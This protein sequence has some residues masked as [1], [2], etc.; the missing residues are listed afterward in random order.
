MCKSAEW[1][2]NKTHR[3]FIVPQLI[4][5]V[6]PLPFLSLPVFVLKIT[7][8]SMETSTLLKNKKCRSVLNSADLLHWTKLF[9][10]DWLLLQRAWAIPLL[11]ANDLHKQAHVHKANSI[12][13]L[14]MYVC[15]WAPAHGSP[16]LVF[17][18]PHMGPRDWTQVPSCWKALSS[19][20]LELHLELNTILI[21]VGFSWSM[22]KLDAS[23]HL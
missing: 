18:F 15:V 10:G 17:S 8:D 14:C 22:H 4:V 6:R 21:T 19:S 9:I 13:L 2:N 16:E 20:A 5:L 1:R 3:Q 23:E 12:Y 11:F 7:S